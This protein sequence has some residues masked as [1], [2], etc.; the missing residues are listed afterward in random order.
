[1]TKED[2]TE[3]LAFRMA[4]SEVTML[5]ELS[6]AEGESDAVVVRRLIREAH[7]QRLGDKKPETRR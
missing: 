1:M 4:P 2:K 7:A 5:R 6:E 3:R